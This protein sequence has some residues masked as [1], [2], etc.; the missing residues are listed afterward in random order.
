LAII[1]VE[2]ETVSQSIDQIK[3]DLLTMDDFADPL[4]YDKIESHLK[5]LLSLQNIKMGLTPFFKINDHFI[6][7]DLHNSNSLLFKHFHTNHDKNALN[8]CCNLLF[9]NNNRPLVFDNLN[10]AVIERIIYLD[11]YAKQGVKSLILCPLRFEDE[12][13][14]ILEIVSDKPFVLNNQHATLI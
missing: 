6:F 14:G 9:H 13:L 1:D 3:K 2:E 7:N 5:S 4:M 8:D 10:T 11:L 12:L